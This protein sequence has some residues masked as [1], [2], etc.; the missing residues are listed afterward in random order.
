MRILIASLAFP[1]IM[2]TLAQTSLD[3]SKPRFHHGPTNSHVF[4][5][6]SS[7]GF[8]RKHITRVELDWLGLDLPTGS[9]SA[10][11][12]IDQAEEDDFS[13]HLLQLGGHWWPSQTFFQRHSIDVDNYYGHHYPPDVDV[14]YCPDGKVLVLKT[15]ADNSEYVPDLPNVPSRKPNE[16]S[17]LGLCRT[18]EER[19]AVLREFG[20]EVL[21]EG[22]KCEE[23]LPKTLGEGIEKGKEYMELL[24]KMEDREYATRWID[25]L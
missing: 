2:A 9:D 22:E 18:M 7:G 25:E 16:W 8:I 15:W 6:P 12:N 1:Q 20:A 11:Q 5:Y 17:K 23:I 10:T 13:L 4:S 24:K 21:G 19:C 3:V 14:A